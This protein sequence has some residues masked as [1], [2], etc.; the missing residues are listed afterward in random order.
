VLE[1]NTNIGQTEPQSSLQSHLDIHSHWRS[2]GIPT[3]TVLSGSFNDTQELW[4][5]WIQGK[6]RDT[7]IW[8][9]SMRQALFVSWL[10]KL[11]AN[12]E[13]HH[14][15]LSYLA[16]TSECPIEQEQI[17]FRLV[18]KSSYELEIFQQQLSIKISTQGSLLLSWFLKQISISRKWFFR[19]LR[20]W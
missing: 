6:G 4:C 14:Q 19:K 2:Q 13:L 8:S 9:P 5:Q 12:P 18:N 1:S 16:T 17:H 3:L 10:E 11:F 7:V 20:T 15:L